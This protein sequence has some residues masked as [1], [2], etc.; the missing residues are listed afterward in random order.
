[1]VSFVTTSP[2][3]KVFCVL[4]SSP[5]S[6]SS[7]KLW[8]R[9]QQHLIWGNQQLVLRRPLR[10]EHISPL[11][12]PQSHKP[13]IPMMGFMGWLEES[14]LGTW[15]TY[16]WYL[17]R[18]TGRQTDKHKHTWSNVC[19]F[20]FKTLQHGKEIHLLSRWCLV[21]FSGSDTSMSFPLSP[22]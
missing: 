18:Q 3:D 22:V 12:G 11:P 16:L 10:D 19:A 9:P 1:M 2:V 14:I 13:K 21:M 15:S 20:D 5:E 7:E 6:G 17:T 8:R 4:A